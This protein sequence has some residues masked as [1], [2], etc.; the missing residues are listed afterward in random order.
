VKEAL[1]A[2]QDQIQKLL[3]SSKKEQSNYEFQLKQLKN[4]VQEL[5]NKLK[6]SQLVC[7]QLS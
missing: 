6:E 5:A 4:K 1:Q 7:D 3:S 2:A